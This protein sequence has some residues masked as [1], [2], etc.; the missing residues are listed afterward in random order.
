MRITSLGDLLKARNS[1]PGG[2]LAEQFYMIGA[3]A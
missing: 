1:C 3:M 2:Q